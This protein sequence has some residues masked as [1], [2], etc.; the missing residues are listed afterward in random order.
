MKKTVPVR[1]ITIVEMLAVIGVIAVLLGIL[2]PEA[3]GGQG[4]TLM[5][6]VIAI[7]ELAMVCPKSADTSN[8]TAA[9]MGQAIDCAWTLSAPSTS[10]AAG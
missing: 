1:G 4:G 8:G 5:D 3:D 10:C 6:A 7:Q 9:A 2:L